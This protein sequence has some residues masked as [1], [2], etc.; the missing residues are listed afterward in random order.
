MW[1]ATPNGVSSVSDGYWK[2]YTSRDG[3]PSDSVTCL[4]EDSS[5]VLWIGTSKGLA[6]FSSGRIRVPREAPESLRSQV[7]GIA[8][9]KHG[10]LW[11]ATSSHV[12]RIQRDHLVAGSLEPA[13]LHE[14][15]LADGLRSIEGVERKNSV[16]V[17][18]HGMLWVYN[19]RGMSV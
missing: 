7:L 4:F 15:G 19:R 2:T 6:F 8:I 10:W 12:M 1:F 18:Q 11:V 3:L 16:V 17:D 13:D 14:Y 9:D 5:G